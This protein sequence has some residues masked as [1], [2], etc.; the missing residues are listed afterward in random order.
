MKTL[1]EIESDVDSA[2]KNEAS[3]ITLAPEDIKLL[4]EYSSIF[5]VN[6]EEQF[7]YSNINGILIQYTKETL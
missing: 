3:V 6:E 5:S 2:L 4:N 7:I 1:E